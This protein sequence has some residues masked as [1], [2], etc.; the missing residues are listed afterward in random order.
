M[1]EDRSEEAGEEQ[2]DENPWAPTGLLLADLLHPAQ[3]LWRHYAFDLAGFLGTWL[4]VLALLVVTI[5]LA[6]IGA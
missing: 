1:S 4:L 5:I 6:R 2:I 3:P